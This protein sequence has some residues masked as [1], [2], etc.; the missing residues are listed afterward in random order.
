[1]NQES[2]NIEWKEGWRDDYLKW[3]CGFANAQGGK[4]YIGKNDKGVVIGVSDAAKLMEDIPNK[5]R[6]VLGIIVD[7]NLLTDNLKTYIEIDIEA[8]PYPINYKGQYHYRTGS[9]KQELKGAALDRFLL[10]KQGKRWDSVPIPHV[11]SKDLAQTALNYFRKNAII[12][13]RLNTDILKDSDTEL[14]E[15]LRLTEGNYLKRA[16]LLLFHPDPEKYVTGAY[17]KIGFFKTDEDLVF[18]DEIHGHLFEQIEKT[19]DILLTKYLKASITYEGLHRKE[20]YPIPESVLRE[21]L[22]NAIA[23]KDYSGSTPIQ[24]SVYADKMIIWNEGQLDNRPVESKTP[25][26]IIQSRYCQR[27][28]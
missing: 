3:I 16:A 20:R 21:A 25:L 27:F 24:I 1:M 6:D 17:I 12:S 14:L 22:L 8:Y 15:K 9:T 13:T 28:F 2:Q 11:S 10:Q 7:V 5:V 23:H 4:I 26:S 18:Q 19:M